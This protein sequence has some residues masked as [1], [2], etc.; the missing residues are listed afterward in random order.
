MG[1]GVN[2]LIILWRQKICFCFLHIFEFYNSSHREGFW[3]LNSHQWRIRHCLSAIP[4]KSGMSRLF[5]QLVK[6]TD[7]TDV[8][9]SPKTEVMGLSK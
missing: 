6:K 3:P 4:F 1:S 2:F 8:D 5:S 9:Y 7:D